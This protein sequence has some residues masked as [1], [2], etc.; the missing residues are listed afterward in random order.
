MSIRVEPAVPARPA[1]TITLLGLTFISPKNWDFRA[2]PIWALDILGL[3]PFGLG[4]WFRYSQVGDVGPVDTFIPSALPRGRFGN[5]PR[6]LIPSSFLWWDPSSRSVFA[7]FEAFWSC[8]TWAL[9]RFATSFS[10]LS[11]AQACESTSSMV[12]HWYFVSSLY[13]SPSGS[14]PL[15]KADIAVEILQLGWIPSLDWRLVGEG[16]KRV[17]KPVRQVDVPLQSRAYQGQTEAFAHGCFSRLLRDCHSENMLFILSEVVIKVS[18]AVIHSHI[19]EIEL[20]RHLDQS[21]LVCEGSISVRAGIASLGGRSYTLE[22]FDHWLN[23]IQ[24]L[25]E[26]S[27]EI[28][29]Y[30]AFA[31][32]IVSSSSSI[33]ESLPS[34]TRVRFFLTVLSLVSFSPSRG[35][36]H[37]AQSSPSMGVSRG[38]MGRTWVRNLRRLPAVVWRAW[39]SSSGTRFSA[40]SWLSFSALSSSCLE[41]SPNVSFRFWTSERSSGLSVT[42]ALISSVT[43]FW[44]ASIKKMKNN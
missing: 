26:Y 5:L 44:R 15:L 41:C 23:G 40:S 32:S 2:K 37:L 3:S 10:H 38:C 34:R 11:C 4:L 43:W 39:F 22:T 9:A 16:R 30:D 24:F 1:L 7:C 14:R 13:R 17:Y 35:W 28:S 19:G 25:G 6:F 21:D 20:L 42:V 12:L 31:A 8:F 36:G 27:F 33:T 29:S 18:S